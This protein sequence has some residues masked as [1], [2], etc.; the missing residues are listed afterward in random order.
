MS[1]HASSG[2]QEINAGYA[3]QEFL[4]QSPNLPSSP[5]TMNRVLPAFQTLLE[6]L[7]GRE[8]EEGT[9]VVGHPVSQLQG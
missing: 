2:F 5:L 6:S 1:Y 8:S 7:L 4:A 3:G 9:P